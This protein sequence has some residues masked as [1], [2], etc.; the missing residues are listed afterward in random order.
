MK[1]Y[2]PTQAGGNIEELFK[3]ARAILPQSN[4]FDSQ[5]K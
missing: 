1:G 2:K 3:L 4:D 5:S